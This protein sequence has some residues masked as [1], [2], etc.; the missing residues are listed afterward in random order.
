MPPTKT[1]PDKNELDLTVATVCR[2][3]LLLLPRCI[4]SVRKLKEVDI[5]YEHLII[6]GASTDG[7][8]EFLVEELNLGRISHLISEPDKGLYDAMNKAIRN[9][10]GKVIVFINSDDEICAESVSACCEPILSGKVGYTVAE[11]LFITGDEEKILSP[12]MQHILWRQPYCHQSM[13]CSTELLHQMGG[14]N[15]TDF[16]IGADTELMRRMYLRDI[17]YK[18]IPLIASHFYAGGISNS[19][20]S[21]SEAYELMFRFQDAYRNEIMKRPASIHAIFKHLRR[22]SV[23]RA[24]ATAKKQLHPLEKERI[25]TFIQAVIPPSFSPIRRFLFRAQLAIQARWYASKSANCT[26]LSKRKIHILNY[27]LT[28]L[29]LENI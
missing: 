15:G 18:I 27:H 19:L 3:A 9:A 5:T 21:C 24:I 22:Y 1:A 16:P 20:A 6:D 7:T 10:K 14:F 25:I 4:E 29:L 23:K 13:Y 8:T 11:A 2:N 17:P 28:R 12:N 26:I